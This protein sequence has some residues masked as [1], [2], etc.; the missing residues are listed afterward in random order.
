MLLDA[1]SFDLDALRMLKSW[2][3]GLEVWEYKNMEI[4]AFT[5]QGHGTR[6]LKH[7]NW[8]LFEFQDLKFEIFN[9]LGPCLWM[10]KAFIW[11]DSPVWRFENPKTSKS[12]L[13]PSRS[14]TPGC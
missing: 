13:L 8:R 3:P 2:P 11:D 9:I 12:N 5:I 4:E 10:L 6:M 14:M 1:K 7:S